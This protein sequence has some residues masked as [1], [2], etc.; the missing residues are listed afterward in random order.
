MFRRRKGPG[1]TDRGSGIL[2]QSLQIAGLVA[3]PGLVAIGVLV[4]AGMLSPLYGM[5]GGGLVLMA[6]TALGRYAGDALATFRAAVTALGE[7]R[8]DDPTPPRLPGPLA[9]ALGS[10]V[11][12]QRHNETARG[13]LAAGLETLERVFDNLP[14]PALLVDGDYRVVRAGSEVQGLLGPLAG[15]TDLRAALADPA[16]EAAVE[17]ALRGDRDEAVVELSLPAPAGHEL[18]ARVRAPHPGGPGKLAVIVFEDLSEAHRV[19]RIRGDFI[20]NISHELRTPLASIIGIAETLAGSAANDP[21]A[22]GRFLDIMDRQAGRMARLVDD[23]LSLSAI[24]LDEYRPPTG[25]VRIGGLVQSVVDDLTARAEARDVRLDL[26]SAFT[27]AGPAVRGDPDQ[28]VEVFENLV[29]NAIKY[30]RRGGTVR[31]VVGRPAGREDNAG[32]GMIQVSVFDE[33]E[34]IPAEHLGRL[35]ERFYRVDKARSREQGGTG[36]GL[37]I[38]KHIVNRHRGRLSIQSNPGKGSEFRVLLPLAAERPD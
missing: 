30:G 15:G 17:A 18:R 20:A 10:V 11:R 24:E 3:I 21:E 12:L 22:R 8:T 37:A 14:A 9:A 23:L 19:D 2:Q 31:I 6:A 7:G 33:G 16:L 26:D 32:P 25:R 35:T 38:V 34:G 13:D 36:L 5:L 4:L 27:G 29:D 1:P 28:L